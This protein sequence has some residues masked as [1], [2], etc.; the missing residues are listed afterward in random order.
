VTVF[1]ATKQRKNVVSGN[2]AA[3]RNCCSHCQCPFTFFLTVPR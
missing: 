3:A 1:A 2:A